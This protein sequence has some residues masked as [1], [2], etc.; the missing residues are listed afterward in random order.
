MRIGFFLILFLLVKVSF[1]QAPL[2]KTYFT[3]PVNIPISLS[4]SFGEL[5]SNHFH[6]GLD[7][8]TQGKIGIEVHAAASG[9]IS[10]L[11]AGVFGY[12]N[13]LYIQH[14]NGYTTVYGHMEEFSPKIRKYLREN[15][16]RLEKNTLE[17]FPE[18]NELPVE[19]GELI[20]LSG[21]SGGAGGPHL[22]FEIRDGAQR[23][24]N[25]FLFGME[26]KDTKPPVVK[27]LQVYPQNEN[28]HVAL[29][30][31]QQELHFTKNKDGSYQTKTIEAYGE[32]GF[33]IE[34]LDYM[35]GSNNT[36]GIY[37]IQTCLNG[38]PQMDI[39]FDDFSFANTRYINRYI[40]YAHF[41]DKKSKVQK[42]FLEANNNIDMQI[43]VLHENGLIDIKDSLDYKFEIYLKDFAGN[44][45]HIKI[46]IRGVKAAVEDL[47][48]KPDKTTEFF[49]QADKP[50]VFELEH[51]DIFIPKD[52]L[53]ENTYLKLSE[54]AGSVD[55]HEFTTPL[56][57]NITIGFKADKYTKE[58]FD[59]LYVARRYPWGTKYYSQTYKED[60]RI[61]T[62]TRTFGTYGLEMDTIPPTIQTLNFRDKK[63]VSDLKYLKLKIKDEESGIA[64]YYGTINGKFIVLEYDYKSGIVRYDFRDK[65][66]DQ[67]ENNLKVIVVD[68]VGNSTTFEA[69]F[70]RKE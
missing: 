6:S 7:I 70:F 12:G 14:P 24:M 18:K 3:N 22:H 15:Q 16:Y 62:R 33:G 9:Y 21:E 48:P 23:P 44:L 57:K 55:V 19:Q 63:W 67:T 17:L 34:A 26:V 69:T 27:A 64:D 50:N 47:K 61:T 1:G 54:S 42:L 11:K 2:P 30:A 59:K 20:G 10:R 38:E 8:R 13:V 49:A 60:N 31:S 37:H 41:K 40:D 29:S 39:T 5:R 28:S 25:P 56:H 58:D 68:N 35:D 32:L 65:I 45:T 46:P 36:H 4:G 52:A 43:N 53:Y 51:H 66:S